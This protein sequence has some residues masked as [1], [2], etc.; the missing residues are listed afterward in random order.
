MNNENA[1]VFY[2]NTWR[3]MMSTKNALGDFEVISGRVLNFSRYK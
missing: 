1:D 2:R 3:D